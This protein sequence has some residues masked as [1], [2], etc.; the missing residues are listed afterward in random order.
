MAPL[1]PSSGTRASAARA[2]Q[3]GHRGLRHHRGEPAGEVEA[4]VGQRPEGVLDVLA[5]DRQE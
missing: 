1:A 2:E 5:E 4:E 3:Q